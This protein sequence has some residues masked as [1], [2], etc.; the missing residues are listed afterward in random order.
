MGLYD[1]FKRGVD[2]VI[3]ATV[4]VAASPVLAAAATAI[5][6]DSPG[7]IIFRQKRLG[8][9]GREFEILKFRS[10]RVGA[11]TMGTGVYTFA[12]DTRVSRVGRFIRATSI[13][14]LPQLVNVLKG[15]MSLIGPRP[16]LTYHPMPLSGYTA[17]QRRMFSVRP[18]LTSWAVVNGRKDVE[19]SRRIAMN[20][21]YAENYS[22][23]LDL[24]ILART[25]M[26]LLTRRGNV[27]TGVTASA[28]AGERNK[29]PRRGEPGC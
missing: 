25:I 11:E 7:P 4:L 28:D 12:G 23:W 20:V 10:M 17:E 16:P 14:E 18:G 26:L 15:D 13:D 21:W 22:L 5:K 2:V 8:L 9:H 1:P 19:W 24:R 29:A 3:A 27:N 6:L